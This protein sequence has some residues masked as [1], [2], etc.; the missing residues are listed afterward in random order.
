MR[1]PLML[2]LLLF[3]LSLFAENYRFSGDSSFS[4]MREGS[5]ESRLKEMWLSN[6]RKEELKR[7]ES[8]L[9][10][11]KKRFSRVQVMFI[12]KTLPGT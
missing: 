9:R 10:E 1:K 8:P 3:C 11:V 2:V 12:L 7:I 4:I 5:E 6:L